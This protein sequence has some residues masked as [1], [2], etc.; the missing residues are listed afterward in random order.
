MFPTN[1]KS[2][3][4]I[5]L[6]IIHKSNNSLFGSKLNGIGD[7]FE[8]EVDF[9]M[10][11]LNGTD[12]SPKRS[13]LQRVDF[14]KKLANQFYGVVKSPL[15]MKNVETR[16]QSTVLMDILKDS[17]SRLVICNSSLYNVFKLSDE[18]ISRFHEIHQTVNKRLQQIDQMLSKY[19][20]IV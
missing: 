6:F 18:D 8:T 20:E 10:G 9:I 15:N 7:F 16:N 12:F 1:T 14:L 2:I 5:A 17:F 11:K 3:I 4:L 13:L 19:P